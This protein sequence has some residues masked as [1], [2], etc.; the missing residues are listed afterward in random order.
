[1]G[2]E[3]RIDELIFYFIDGKTFLKIFDKRNGIDICAYDLNETE[4]GVL[5][6]CIDVISYQEITELLPHISDEQLDSILSLFISKG[7]IFK[8]DNQYLSLPLRLSVVRMF[9]DLHTYYL[10]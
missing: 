2:Q 1:M 8:K 6:A 4:R 5:L 9:G 7:I 10:Q 3:N